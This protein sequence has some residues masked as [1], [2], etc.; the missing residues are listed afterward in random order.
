MS[1]DED[2]D[3]ETLDI[4]NPR[5]L[6]DE[7]VA[8]KWAQQRVTRED[9]AESTD[10]R[11]T[12]LLRLRYAVGIIE[13]FMELLAGGGDPWLSAKSGRVKVVDARDDKEVLLLVAEGLKRRG[14][15]VLDLKDE[16]EQYHVLAQK[17]PP[18][19]T[20]WSVIVVDPILSLK[21]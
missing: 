11:R 17:V 8:E 21:P 1:I 10:V 4:P 6:T 3:Q 2:L 16:H 9:G 20:R 19:T 7:I 5:P 13:Q 12:H 15:T 14:F 18:G